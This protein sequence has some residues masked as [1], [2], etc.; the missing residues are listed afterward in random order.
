M[1]LRPALAAAALLL[2]LSG[3][4]PAPGSAAPTGTADPAPTSTS[5]TPST[6]PPPSVTPAPAPSATAAP[7]PQTEPV[8]LGCS[9]VLSAQA[10]YDYNSNV[11]LLGEFSPAADSLAGEAVAQQGI[12]CQ[13]IN[14][15]SGE[16]IDI[17]VVRFTD[18]G[19]ASK[20][21]SV[22][23]SSSPADAFDGFFDGGIAQAFSAP[24]WVTMTSV[25]FT[26]AGDAAGLVE[27][28]VAGL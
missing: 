12:A 13:L 21:E 17:G 14:Q 19:Y 8:D 4:V 18:A 20:L 9:D 27:A 26:E 10:I 16:T 2:L 7:V 23:A 3:C 25:G 28:A 11:S 22:S 6:T 15:T 24:Y 1:L 5:T